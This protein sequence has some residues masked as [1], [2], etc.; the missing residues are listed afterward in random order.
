MLLINIRN[1]LFAQSKLQKYYLNPVK[2]FYNKLNYQPNMEDDKENNQEEI[3]C[4]SV[5]VG[6]A[7]SNITKLFECRRSRSWLDQSSE[8]IQKSFT[9]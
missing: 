7:F 4:L 9:R 8:R 2:F 6:I 3:S 1:K 5:K